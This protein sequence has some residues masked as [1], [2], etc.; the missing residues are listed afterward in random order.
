MSNGRNGGYIMDFSKIWLSLDGIKVRLTLNQSQEII[1]APIFH[2]HSNYYELIFCICPMDLY[3]DD[4]KISISQGNAVFI[5]P[6]FNHA[7]KQQKGLTKLVAQF[8]ADGMREIWNC[9][10]SETRYRVIAFSKAEENLMYMIASEINEGLPGCEQMAGGLCKAMFITASRKLGMKSHSYDYSDNTENIIESYIDIENNKK[11]TK[12]GLAALL[13]VSIRQV[14]R[15]IHQK[16]G[17]T[18]RDYVNKPR[19]EIAKSLIEHESPMEDVAEFLGY[20]SVN[21]FNRAY[22]NQ[23]KHTKK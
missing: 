16:F 21:S 4:C 19:F 5:P 1:Q 20:S 9:L 8:E 17:M 13:N 18:F 12:A 3:C 2:N 6:H 22:K 14:D 11:P 23:F 10:L 15:L 7:T